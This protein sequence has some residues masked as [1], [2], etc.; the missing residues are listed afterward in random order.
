MESFSES[1]SRTCRTS[2]GSSAATSF[3]SPEDQWLVTGLAE[4]IWETDFTHPITGHSASTF[5]GRRCLGDDKWLTVDTVYTPT[6]AE[7]IVAVYRPRAE[8]PV[9]ADRIHLRRRTERRRARRPCRR[10]RFADRPLP[11]LCG[12]CGRFFGN[13]PLWHFDGRLFPTRSRGNKPWTGTAR[14]TWPDC[15]MFSWGCRGT[16]CARRRRRH[17]DGR[18]WKGHHESLDRAEVDK[19]NRSATFLRPAPMAKN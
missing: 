1:G 6:V 15:E 5:L 9:R 17:R 10:S 16:A 12:A 18:V 19:R 7:R 11:M 2:F 8:S 13:N 14:A 4:G 3:L